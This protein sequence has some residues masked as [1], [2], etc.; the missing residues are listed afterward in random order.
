MPKKLESQSLSFMCAFDNARNVSDGKTFSFPPANDRKVWR[1]R[2]EG[3]IGDLRACR[4][5]C[6]NQRRF[7]SVGKAHE[8]YIGQ[9]F[10]FESKR[11]FFAFRACLKLR[12]S[13]IG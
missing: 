10:Q 13:A 4:R 5:D 7:S 8:P 2:G 3:I 9:Q 6:R 11:P 12:G 1:Q